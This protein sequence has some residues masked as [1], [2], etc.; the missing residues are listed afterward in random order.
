MDT[1]KMKIAVVF[2]GDLQGGGGY[3]YQLSALVELQ[4]KLQYHFVAFVFSKKNQDVVQ[5]YSIETVYCKQTPF[6]T[7]FRYINRQEWF[8]I[9]SSFFKFKCRYEKK[10]D[11]YNIDIVYFLSPSR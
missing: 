4:R 1:S 3:Q 8:Y 10:L 11:S 7:V 2:E 9:F 5:K 6:D